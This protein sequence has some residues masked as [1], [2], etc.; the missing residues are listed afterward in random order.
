MMFNKTHKIIFL[1]LGFVFIFNFNISNIQGEGFCST[2]SDC[3][4]NNACEVNGSDGDLDMSCQG[5][6]VSTNQGCY[7]GTCS[8]SYSCDSSCIATGNIVSSVQCINNSCQYNYSPSSCNAVGSTCGYVET[9][10]EGSPAPDPNVGGTGGGTV[11]SCANPTFATNTTIAGYEF[12]IDQGGSGW[13]GVGSW[14]T[15]IIGSI[16]D[17]DGGFEGCPPGATCTK[18]TS[19]INNPIYNPGFVGVTVTNT[20]STPPGRYPMTFTVIDTTQPN[21]S[22]EATVDVV[23][24]I[25]RTVVCDGSYHP[26]P[27]GPGLTPQGVASLG[28]AGVFVDSYFG[29]P[30]FIGLTYSALNKLYTQICRYTSGVGSNCIWGY[31]FSST[32]PNGVNNISRAPHVMASPQ[33]YPYLFTKVRYDS[34]SST[35]T[36]TG[37]SFS[38]FTNEGNT[39][40][41]WGTPIST[42][43]TNSR[44]YNFRKNGSYYEYSCSVSQ[45]DLI[46]ENPSLSGT[47]TTGS[48]LTFGGRIR[49]SG[50]ANA[51]ATQSRLI[52]D[53]NSNGFGVGSP[54]DVVVNNATAGLLALP[55]SPNFE[56]ESWN[57]TAVAGTHVYRITADAGSAVTESNEGNNTYTSGSFTVTAPNAVPDINVSPSTINSGQSSTVSWTSTGATS[58]AVSCS[59]AGSCSWTGTS[60]SQSSGALSANKTYTLTCQ[61]GNVADSATVTV[62]AASD[63]ILSVIKSGQGTVTSSPVG[64]SCGTDCSQ[65]YPLNTSVTLTATPAAGRIFTGWS[66]H[67]TGRGTETS[68][69]SGIF[70]CTLNINGDKSVTAN[71]AID[72]NYKEF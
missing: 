51:A 8:I 19:D 59:P 65:D 41:P 53:V 23:I 42:V 32:T 1:L 22:Q 35:F 60:G 14:P 47:Q 48:T 26:I 31:E 63:P 3:V 46:V 36:R 30:E 12:V 29:Q 61:P 16:V 34:L 44:T 13:A 43:D 64:I 15:N 9:Y 37:G 45:P 56:N 38:T 20:A 2:A 28:P 10:T 11:V 52:I 70:T 69:G 62:N 67:C 21:C 4:A 54:A 33:P 27:P 57:W 50:N 58:C 66:G 7:A 72:P 49:N 6:W 25:P 5:S 68:P 71:F 40:Y 39:S 18:T 55:G 17:I 24:S